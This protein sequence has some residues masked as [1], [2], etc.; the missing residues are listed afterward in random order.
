MA[1]PFLTT[2]DSL[3]APSRSVYA[4]T[5]HDANAL[6]RLPKALY[7]GTGGDVTL[8]CA[9]DSEDVIFRNVPSGGIIRARGLC[10]RHGDHGFV[11]PG[12]L[13]MFGFGFED[14]ADE[15]VQSG[16]G[17]PSYRA[18]ASTL[19]ARMT[20]QPSAARKTAIDS[21][22][23]TL[24]DAGI[25]AK[26]DLL[27]I[28]AAHD[29]QAACLNWK[30]ASHAASIG[31]GAP[32]FIPDRGWFCDGIDDRLRTGWAP[33]NGVGYAQND[34]CLGIWVRNGGQRSNAPV[35]SGTA[36][37]ALISPRNASD[38]MAVRI[39]SS[40]STTSTSAITDGYGL[41]VA[42]RTA[43]NAVT[44]WKAGVQV[45]GT[46]T[47]ASATLSAVEIEFGRSNSS[48][49]EQQAQCLF[50]GAALDAGQQAAIHAALEAYLSALGVT[51]LVAA[52]VTLPNVSRQILPDG[53]HPSLAGRGLPCTG[54]ARDGVDGSLWVGW[55]LGTLS[56]FAGLAHVSADGATLLGEYATAALG[57][58]AGIVVPATSSSQGVAFDGRDSTLWWIAKDSVNGQSWLCHAARGE[59]PVLLSCT[60]LPAAD[61]NGVAVDTLRGQIVLLATS[62]LFR[63]YAVDGSGVATLASPARGASNPGGGS[64]QI[65]YVA[66][67][68]RVLVSGGPNGSDG[69]IHEFAVS[70]EYGGLWYRRN[71]TLGGA[72]AVEGAVWDD[73]H[74]VVANDGY[75]HTSGS[76]PFNALHRF[77][78]EM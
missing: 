24:V 71:F 65:H 42:N 62:G 46:F 2:A 61:L 8:R 21:L 13:L 20:M 31:A 44:L 33:A 37:A 47:T 48:F 4:V 69:Y 45:D 29:A 74:F 58:A 12:A 18:E 40:A 26:L 5:P 38:R 34:A 73:G 41:S 67:H 43:S 35:G 1:D 11:H 63:W 36:A 66:S 50:A 51:P 19:F 30:G 17:G 32:V 14:A 68:D 59:P 72:D 39:N 78:A 22:V 6:P 76:F 55:G 9:D 52:P 64:D 28:Y 23:G 25:W 7:V 16:G 53:A 77:A 56:A 15:L 27:H 75:T 57:S 3:S 54:L 49:V 70:E 10:P 60:L